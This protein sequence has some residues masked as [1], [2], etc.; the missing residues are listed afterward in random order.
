MLVQSSQA[1][2]LTGTVGFG[3]GNVL[4]P[5]FVNGTTF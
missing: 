3:S 2:G 1:A 4:T 5:V